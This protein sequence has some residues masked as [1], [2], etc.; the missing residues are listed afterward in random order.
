MCLFSTVDVCL[1]NQYNRFILVYLYIDG[2]HKLIR[3]KMVT[4]AG[5]DAIA[6]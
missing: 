4:H 5:I 2:H 1:L 6:N 3:W